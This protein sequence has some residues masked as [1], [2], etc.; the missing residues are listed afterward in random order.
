MVDHGALHQFTLQAEGK[1]DAG[2]VD[3][4]S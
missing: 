3:R 1:I 2:I 4:E